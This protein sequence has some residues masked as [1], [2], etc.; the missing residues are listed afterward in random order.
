MT[1]LFSSLDVTGVIENVTMVNV[2]INGY[3]TFGSVVG[4]NYGTVKNI[5]VDYARLYG[6]NNS[7]GG[8]VGYMID[9]A[10]VIGAMA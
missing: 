7:I 10:T 9:G 6:S 2:Y 4:Y 5:N 3:Y 8:V 1:S